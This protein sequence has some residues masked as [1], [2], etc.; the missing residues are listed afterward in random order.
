MREA[1]AKLLRVFV[2]EGEKA[3]HRLLYEVVVREA[4]DAGM[5]GATA[6]RGIMGFGGGS[7]V[8]HTA[9]LLDLSAELPVV[10]EIVDEA[11]KVERFA[12][13]LVELFEREGYGGLV[14]I[15][16]A[17]VLLY[18]SGEEGG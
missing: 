6:W 2:G 14:T 15:E 9:K 1:K 16:D 12:R 13:R 7:K 17:K 5:A 11:E 4:W 10:V 3:R 8:I 18:R